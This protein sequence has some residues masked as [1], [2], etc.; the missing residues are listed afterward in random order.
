MRVI[1]IQADPT[2]PSVAINVPT[3]LAS[4]VAWEHGGPPL[5][6]VV[7]RVIAH[8]GFKTMVYAATMAQPHSDHERVFFWTT[9]PKEWVIEYDRHSYVE[10]DPRIRIGLAT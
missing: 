8:L 6:D 3:W 5:A 10:V 7:S 4:L 2:A 9:A 1:P